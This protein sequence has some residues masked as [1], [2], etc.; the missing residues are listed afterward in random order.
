M[1]FAGFNNSKVRHLIRLNHSKLI[2]KQYVAIQVLRYSNTYY[3]IQARFDRIVT[4]IASNKKASRDKH[5]D[6]TP[7]KLFFSENEF[8]DFCT[9]DSPTTR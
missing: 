9:K 1:C 5:Y 6:F 2:K 8:P 4:K 7:D 3:T